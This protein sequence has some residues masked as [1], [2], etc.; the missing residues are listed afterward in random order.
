MF[1]HAA[2]C[3]NPCSTGSPTKLT[4][5]PAAP[6]REASDRPRGIAFES[7]VGRRRPAEPLPPGTEFLD[8]ETAG[9]KSTRETVIVGRD[10]ERS[11]TRQESPRKRPLFDR[12]RFP[13]FGKTGWWCAQSPANWSLAELPDKWLFTGYF[14]ELLADIAKYA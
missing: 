7:A 4:A 6:D 9:P 1:S 10:R 2:H 14:R 11:N 8:A 12:R 13:R 3:R 5:L